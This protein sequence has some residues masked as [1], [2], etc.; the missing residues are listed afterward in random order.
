LV[1]HA[2]PARVII[3]QPDPDPRTAG[4]GAARIERAGIPTEILNDAASAASLGGYLTRQ[5]FGRPF[6]TLK[7]AMSLDGC[8][9]LADGTSQWITGDA[10]RA[11]VHVQRARH[12]AILVGG[13]T[14]CIDRPRLDVRLPGLEARSPKR[15][16]LTRGVQPGGVTIIKS[17][18]QI[19]EIEGA[20]YLYVEGGAGTAASF[21]QGDLVD[22]LHIYR[23]PIII[24]DGLRSV[25]ALG[26][27]N[28]AAAHD[29]WK[30]SERR[31]LGS[32]TFESYERVRTV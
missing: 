11:H 13:K 10:A 1:I 7:L 28:L 25:A 21:L 23:A 16:V 31:Q 32:D 6:V 17:P 27:A 14:W 19:G 9:A 3:G 8:I 12:D 18:A 22:A 24:G 4:T 26:L 15:V 2:R 30:I 29:R 5:R 20:H